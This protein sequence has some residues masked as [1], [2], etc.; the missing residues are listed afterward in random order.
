[1]PSE[2][3]SNSK[4]VLTSDVEIEG[5]LRFEGELI[6]DGKIKGE[7][8]SNG[9]L[10]LGKASIIDR[11]VKVKSVT[12]YGKVDGNVTVSE[13]CELKSSAQLN[14]DLKAGCIMIEAGACFV[15]KSEVAPGKPGK[16]SEHSRNNQLPTPPASSSPEPGRKALHPATGG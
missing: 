3:T 11:E 9:G 12:I 7:I 16:P 2:P 5:I 13:K 14:G 4:N 6:F 1:M 8:V 15:G 10:T